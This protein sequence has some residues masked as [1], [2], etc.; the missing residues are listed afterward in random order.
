MSGFQRGLAAIGRICFSLIFISA[1]INKVMNWESS[2]Q[3]LVNGL[4]DFLS[5]TYN[6]GWAQGLFDHLLPLS[7]TLLAIAAA[8]EILGGLMIFT[9]LWVRLG[10]FALCIF[11]IPVTLIFHSFWWLEGADKQLQM[12][13]FLK[14]LSMFGATLILLAMGKG[15]RRVD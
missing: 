2:E 9:G 10:A 5:H 13:M 14:N 15:R 4:L 11:L 8:I 3:Y 6:Q 7:A 12:I 1:G